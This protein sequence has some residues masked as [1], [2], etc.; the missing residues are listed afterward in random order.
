MSSDSDG[1][2]DPA[3]EA[4]VVVIGKSTVEKTSL[5]TIA[6]SGAPAGDSMP[7]V[8]AN[9]STKTH[10]YCNKEVV[11]HI[12][13]TAGHERFR[14]MTPLYYRGARVILF[15]FAIDDPSS[16]EEIDHWHE[17]VLSSIGPSV[18]M[19]LVGNK[20]DLPRQVASD[21]A[22]KKADELNMSCYMETS[23]VTG[24]GV[25][26][27]FD[28]VAEIAVAMGEKMTEKRPHIPMSAVEDS[29]KCC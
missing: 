17:S 29:A 8:G 24:D 19:V 27:L 5:I 21:Q 6:T 7:T 22:V 26:E 28:K 4:K 3:A 25:N 1:E 20:A 13:D 10:L 2:P 12:W 23:A 18:G 11:I 15:V 9:F 16:F 14:A